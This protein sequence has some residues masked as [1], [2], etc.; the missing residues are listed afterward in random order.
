MYRVKVQILPKE[1]V[2]DPQG[3]TVK[4]ALEKLG[5]DG[6]K[7]VRLGKL[8][9]I[10]LEAEDKTQVETQVTIMCEKLLANP[11]IESYHLLEVEEVR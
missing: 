8:I 11:V 3:Q 7:E 2:F 6:V 9:E 10:F 4:G 1:G 5:F